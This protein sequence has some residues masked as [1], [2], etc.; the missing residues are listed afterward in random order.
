MNNQLASLKK[1]CQHEVF[2]H[3]MIGGFAGHPQVHPSG[4]QVCLDCGLTLKEIIKEAQGF[5]FR[6]LEIAAEDGYRIGRESCRKEI[7]EKILKFPFKL[8]TY[9][10]KDIGKIEV[11]VIKLFKYRDDILKDLN[12]KGGG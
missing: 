12:K 7:I 1:E 10:E 4:P 8:G 5:S 11:D 9:K 6:E 3:K 2:G